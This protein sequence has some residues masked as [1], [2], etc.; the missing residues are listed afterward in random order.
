M[1]VITKAIQLNTK[2]EC[3]IIDL[4]GAVREALAKSGLERGTV[5][6]FVPGATA[7][8]T[9]VEFEDGLVQDLK[10]AFEKIAPRRGEYAHNLRW[11]D[12]NG[13]SHVRASI[14]GPSLSAPFSGRKLLLGTWQQIV[15]IDFDN[16]P[17][18]REV[19]FQF[20]GEKK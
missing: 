3:D 9:T 14:L 16:R 10:T 17:R 20:T 12:G 18:S 6:V 1:A 5:T 4:T 19:V 7:G 15:L 8:V 2:G 11:S 13:F